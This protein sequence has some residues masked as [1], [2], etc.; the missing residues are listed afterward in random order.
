MISC[1]DTFFHPGNGIYYPGNGDDENG[2][3]DPDGHENGI[4]DPDGHENGI[5]DP[6]EN[7]N[8]IYD[9]EFG[10]GTDGDLHS[11]I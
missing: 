4:Y 2:I 1:G 5:Y 7:E 10:A 6:G 9:L 8:E 11:V 3:Y